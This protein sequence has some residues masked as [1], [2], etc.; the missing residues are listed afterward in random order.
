[1]FILPE[2]P[3]AKDALEPYISVRTLALENVNRSSH[4]I[5]ARQT[6]CKNMALHWNRMI[7]HSFSLNPEGDGK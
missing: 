2:L 6:I 4:T 1:M 3:Y 5:P 7:P